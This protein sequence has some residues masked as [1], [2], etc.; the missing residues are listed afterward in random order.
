MAGREERLVHGGELVGEPIADHHA[1]LER[2]Q[3]AVALG[4]VPH[5]DLALADV[6]LAERERREPHVPVGATGEAGEQVL[7]RVAGEGT[8]VVPR[9]GEAEGHTGWNA[10]MGRVH[11]DFGQMRRATLATTTPVAMP[12]TTSDGW[13][14]FT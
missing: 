6:D 4:L 5:V 9:D 13:W 14:I 11:S 10:S 7:V 2:Q 8:A 1:G 3:A 12:A